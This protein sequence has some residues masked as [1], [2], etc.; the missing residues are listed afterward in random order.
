LTG[1]PQEVTQLL[2]AWRDGDQQALDKLMPLVY[3]ELRR[4]AHRYMKRQ[5]DG[6]TLQTTAVVHE[7]YLR[8]AGRDEVHWQNRAHFF[9]V[10]AQMMRNLL[11]DRARARQ[12]DKR[13][14]GINQVEL[15]E[16]ELVAPAQLDEVL[17]L[18]EALEKLSEIDPRKSRIIEMRYFG[19][20]SVE[21]TA[22][23][24][25]LSPITIKREWLK[26]RAWLYLEMNPASRQR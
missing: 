23:V 21:E 15:D 26:A 13:G 20:M 5:K 14:G 3:D 7:A 11:V 4:L 2:A 9:A 24:L 19:G 22:A 18:N 25:E 17:E 8:L 16:G 1:T 10:C 6:Q 12:A